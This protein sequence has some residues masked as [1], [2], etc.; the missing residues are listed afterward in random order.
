ML[1]ELL[2]EIYYARL[3]EL[4]LA[5]TGSSRLSENGSNSPPL[6]SSARLSEGLLL[7]QELKVHVLSTSIYPGSSRLSENGSNS[8][9]LV[10][11]ARLSEGLLLEQELKV[12]FVFNLT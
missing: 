1:L 9:P 5:Q 6:V 2:G 11:S 8:P 10:S 7:E 12:L 4:F 3:S